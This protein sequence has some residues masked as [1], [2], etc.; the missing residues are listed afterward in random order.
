MSDYAAKVFGFQT[1]GTVYGLII[2][3]SGILSFTQSGLQAAVH[4]TYH[5]NPGPVNLALRAQA[6]YS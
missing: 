1:F 3:L 5:R 6:R 2:T 4:N